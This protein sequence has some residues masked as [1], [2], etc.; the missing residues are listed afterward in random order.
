MYESVNK[1]T[2]MRSGRNS[3]GERQNLVHP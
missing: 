3:G 2:V 1:L